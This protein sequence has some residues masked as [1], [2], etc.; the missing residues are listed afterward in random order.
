MYYLSKWRTIDSSTNGYALPSVLFL[1]TILSLVVLS[2]LAVKYFQRQQTQ[3]EIAHVKADYAAQSGIASFIVEIKTKSYLPGI[4]NTIK[5]E[6]DLGN[7]EEAYVTIEWWGLYIL[8]SSIGKSRNIQEKRVA[9][10][11]ER[12]TRLFANALVFGNTNHQLVITGSSYIKGDV[13][14]GPAGISIGTLKDLP[15]P[16]KL[17]IE[18]KV[19]RESYINLP[20]M[21]LKEFID[22]FDRILQGKTPQ[23]I[24]QADVRYLQSGFEVPLSHEAID[25]TVKFIFLKGNLI[26]DSVL[27]QRDNPIYVAVD[28]QINIKENACVEGLICIASTQSIDIDG[29]IDLD[30]AIVY[31][32]K[33]IRLLQNTNVTAQLI[34]PTITIES[35]AK[36]SYPSV[37][38]SYISKDAKEAGNGIVIRNGAQVGGSVIAITED[39]SKNEPIMNI[40]PSA[41]ING[42]VVTNGVITLDGTVDGCVMTKDFYFY[43][44]P[45]I[46]LGWLRSARIDRMQCLV[47]H[48]DDSFV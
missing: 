46:Y 8:A 31:S 9:L 37:L 41:G 32:K 7:D 17:P 1:I 42:F 16:R 11:G 2:I 15:I 35:G 25:A 26:I 45:T 21:K 20:N 34:A 30:E 47:V 24:N 36:A 27:I 4:G 19:K 3:V 28:G 39:D 14:T 40:E 10:I 22:Y 12:P 48:S 38:L 29:K 13:V 5:R 18:G 6:F 44:A 23:G 33:E 43:E